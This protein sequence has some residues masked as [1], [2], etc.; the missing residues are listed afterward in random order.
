MYVYIH[1][2]T[3]AWYSRPWLCSRGCCTGIKI[4]RF[5]TQPLC[6]PARG[7]F[8]TGTSPD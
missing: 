6:T 8:L 1:K 5:Y 2:L 7:A 3:P 4:E